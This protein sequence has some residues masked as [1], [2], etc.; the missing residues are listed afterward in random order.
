MYVDTQLLHA[1]AWPT[2]GL[3]LALQLGYYLHGLLKHVFLR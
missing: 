2:V 1:L 3:L